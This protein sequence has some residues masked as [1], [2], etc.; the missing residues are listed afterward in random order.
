MAK[1]KK[2]TLVENEDVYDIT[3]ENN[4][5]FYANDILVHNCFEVSFIP[6]TQ[7][8]RCGVQFCNLSSINGA[9]VNTLEDWKLA[10][11]AAAIVGTLQAAY[12][13]FPFLSNTSKELTEEEALLGVSI[14]GFMD[15]PDILLNYEYQREMAK[16]AV[17]VNKEWTELI[18]INQAAR[19]TLTK[20]E[21]SSSLVLGSASGIHPHHSHR[22]IRRIQC[23]KIDPVYQHFHSFNPHASEES[24]W[25]ANKTD[26]VVS[27]PVEVDPS[28]IVK[29]DLTAI[30]HL[31]IIKN[32]QINWVDSGATDKNKKPIRHNVSCTVIVNNQ[33]DEWDRVIDYLYDNR[34]YFSAVSLL[35][36]DGDQIY[37]Q[38]PLE[39]VRPDIEKKFDELKNNWIPVDYTSLKESTDNTKQ[40]QTVVCAGNQCELKSL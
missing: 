29:S 18:G 23:N 38:A 37:K 13:D 12:T 4:H 19:V 28:S 5:N 2:I 8:G 17:A 6:V 30:E 40:S 39:A 9:K 10:T 26:D 21:G 22:Y 34:N 35:G 24:V 7:D 20:P 27:F 32:T 11:E 33:G 25:S 1:I 16:Y 3:V 31:E 15:N 14:T 36:S